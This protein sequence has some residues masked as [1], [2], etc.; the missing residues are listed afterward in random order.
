MN[1]SI[2]TISTLGIKHLV[3]AMNA[4]GLDSSSVLSVAGISPDDLNDPEHR[5]P[6]PQAGLVWQ[7]ALS[8][9]GDEDI[10]LKLARMHLPKDRDV[11][12]YLVGTSPTVGDG[13]RRLCRFFPLIGDSPQLLL[14]EERELMIFEH[15]IQAPVVL[16][17]CVVEFPMAINVLAIR[18]S[19]GPDW[20]PMEVRF[21]HDSPANTSLHKEIF[22]C[23]VGFGAEADSIVL[24][25]SLIDQPLETSNPNLGNVLERYAVEML[26]RLP[27]HVP[28]D[29]AEGDFLNK[30]RHQVAI[31]LCD[32]EP[33]V[34]DVARACGMSARTM[35][36]RLK[37]RSMSFRE[38]VDGLRLT[39]AKHRLEEGSLSIDEIAFTLG[40]SEASAFRR[41]FRR[42]TGMSP[43]IYRQSELSVSLLS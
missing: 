6:L 40:F 18:D 23:P 9:S 26:S 27:E 1:I 41:A 11:L 3:Y 39:M 33:R 13:I 10:G 7:A 42:W 28:R 31:R 16:P 24:L 38:I 5:F 29:Q 30:L 17:R 22:R 34:E 43:S 4:F 35:H 19:L 2:G 12:T 25:R 15:R 8:L 37:D 14:R 32:G 21:A 36:R 20:A